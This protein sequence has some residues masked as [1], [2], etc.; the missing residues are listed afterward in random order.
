MGIHI[1]AVSVLL[2][3]TGSSHVFGS[4]FGIGGQLIGFLEANGGGGDKAGVGDF[5]KGTAKVGP[6]A[7][8]VLVRTADEKIKVLT[9]KNA[10]ALSLPLSGKFKAGLVAAET[11]SRVT[12]SKAARMS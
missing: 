9:G 1:E 8:C 11:L 3:V 7:K 6:G 10:D 12:F 5:G 4:L 2:G